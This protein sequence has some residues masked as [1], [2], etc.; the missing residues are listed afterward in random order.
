MLGNAVPSLIAE[1]LGREIS[2][3]FFGAEIISP[4]KLLPPRRQP[5][6]D[7]EKVCRVPE[8]YNHHIGDHAPHPGTGKGKLA[9]KRAVGE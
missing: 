2:S 4:L 6:P 5:I 9:A 1:V 8:K 3:Q 7:P